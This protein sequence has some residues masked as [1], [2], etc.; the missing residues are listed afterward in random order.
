MGGREVR[1][2]P[3]NW[4]HPI[5]WE[6]YDA[7]RGPSWLAL[8]GRDMIQ[9][10]EEGEEIVESEF[11]PDW[12]EEEATHFMMYE[13]VSEGTPMSPAFETPEELARW[14]AD[15]GANYGAFTTATYETWLEVCRDEAS[16]C[17][18]YSRDKGVR[19]ENL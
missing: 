5:D 10:Y 9:Y 11:M 1:K 17:M 13:T 12:T 4:R 8:Q 7:R 19:F 3:K 15:H 2:V 18:V 16:P 14:L 6:R